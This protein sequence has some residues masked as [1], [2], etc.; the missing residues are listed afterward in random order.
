VIFNWDEKKNNQLKK[1]RNISFEQ[2]II[3]IENGEILDV[4]VN[5]SVQYKNQILI[6]VNHNDY[7][8][9]IPSVIGEEEIFL[10]TIFPSRKYT[11]KYIRDRGGE[12]EDENGY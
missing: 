4:L 2:I 3:D 11:N 12:K 7:A 10:K 6:V 8:Y 1:T 9:V 5:P